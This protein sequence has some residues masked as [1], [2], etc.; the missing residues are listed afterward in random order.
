MPLKFQIT[1][2]FTH[3]LSKMLKSLKGMKKLIHI[4]REKNQEILVMYI[5][6]ILYIKEILHT[7]QNECQMNSRSKPSIILR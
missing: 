4:S 5:C 7:R 3:E 1:S 6:Y 2:K